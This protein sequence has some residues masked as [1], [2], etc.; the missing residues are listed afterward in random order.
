MFLALLHLVVNLQ[1]DAVMVWKSSGTKRSRTGTPAAGS[2]GQTD[3][4]PVDPLSAVPSS[5]VQHPTQQQGSRSPVALQTNATSVHPQSTAVSAVPVAPLSSASQQLAWKQ[6][7]MP[8]SFV[9]EAIDKERSPLRNQATPDKQH[10]RQQ[11]TAQETHACAQAN[12]QQQPQQSSIKPL[13]HL[14]MQ[15]H[16]STQHNSSARPSSTPGWAATKRSAP[17]VDFP[18]P[19][20]QG[21]TGTCVSTVPHNTPAKRQKVTACSHANSAVVSK[22]RTSLRSGAHAANE[23]QVVAATAA[24]GDKSKAYSTA[25][26]KQGQVTLVNSTP[27]QGG[28][29]GLAKNVMGSMAQRLQTGQSVP[30]TPQQPSAA[31]RG[32]SVLVNTATADKNADA[33][34]RALMQA[35]R[36]NQGLPKVPIRGQSAVHAGEAVSGAHSH[37]Q[38][39]PHLPAR[40]SVPARAAATRPGCPDRTANSC[41]LSAVVH[42][43]RPLHTAQQNLGAAHQSSDNTQHRQGQQQHQAAKQHVTRQSVSSAAQH[44]AAGRPAH[45]LMRSASADSSDSLFRNSLVGGCKTAPMRDAV[46]A[47]VSALTQSTAHMDI[48]FGD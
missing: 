37:G 43:Q 36:Q 19:K 28:L 11:Q 3:P 44:E 13:E 1:A 22:Q 27:G 35:A 30:T 46:S 48:S 4:R 31:A 38:Q 16:Q 34:Q 33:A 21:P 6:R 39:S 8:C 25:P 29:W 42:L 23:Q 20:Q 7:A 18:S 47:A 15:Q 40:A 41:S 5:A 14:S 10:P 45:G 24:Q 12:Q 17:A 9:P 2:G 26:L 32:A